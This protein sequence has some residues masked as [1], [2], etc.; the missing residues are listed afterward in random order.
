MSLHPWQFHHLAL[1]N[2]NGGGDRI[3]S[4]WRAVRNIMG[5]DWNVRMRSGVTNVVD[6]YMDVPTN[7]QLDLESNATA[8]SWESRKEGQNV[9]RLQ[10]SRSTSTWYCPWAKIVSARK[11]LGAPGP[12][13]FVLH[14]PGSTELIGSTMNRKEK[15]QLMWQH[16]PPATQGYQVLVGNSIDG[17]KLWQRSFEHFAVG[18]LGSC[19][20][21]WVHGCYSRAR[22]PPNFFVT[23]PT[24]RI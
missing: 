6:V 3:S 2:R 13:D 5:E 11:T 15:L 12:I 7:H 1:G 19:V 4:L 22:R 9:R 24:S 18:E 10:Y 17:T 20:P 21:F 14:T 23:W 8:V 16:T